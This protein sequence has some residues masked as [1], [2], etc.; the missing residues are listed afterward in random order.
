MIKKIL[1]YEQ[2]FKNG[3]EAGE[4][5]RDYYDPHLMLA[6]NHFKIDPKET[7]L[8]AITGNGYQY[9][10]DTIYSLKIVEPDFQYNYPLSCTPSLGIAS[11]LCLILK[12]CSPEFSIYVGC[13]TP[14]QWLLDMPRVNSKLCYCSI[15]DLS[16][17][18]LSLQ[19]LGGGNDME[20]NVPMLNSAPDNTIVI[21]Y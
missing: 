17:C 14:L 18:R 3:R 15:A 11:Q 5:P 20:D 6:E 2:S 19:T 1:N 12:N 10:D 4:S 13:K 16:Q 7:V 9:N 8:I 21:K